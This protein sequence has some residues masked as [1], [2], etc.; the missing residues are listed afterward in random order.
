MPMISIEVPDAPGPAGTAEAYLAEP[1]GRDVSGGGVLL[2]M[3]AIGLRPQLERMADRIAGWGYPTLAPNV[4]YRKGSAAELAPREDLRVPKARE[5]FFRKAMPRVN[6]LTAELAERDI[7]GYLAALRHT[8]GDPDAEVAVVGFCMGARLAVRAAG[9]DPNVVACAGFHGGGLATDA[10]DSPHWRLATARAEFVFGHADKDRSMP[11][12]AVAE[13]GAAMDK[14]G[15][16]YLN[17]IYPGAPHGYTM[18]D[19]SSF[20]RAGAERAFT[21]LRALLERTLPRP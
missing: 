3:D 21:E 13:L 16:T 1:G 12:E 14:I 5:A 8:L 2:F 19:T 4:F 11:P 7:P 9:L 6:A 20:Q 10:D 18:E 17:E 15:L